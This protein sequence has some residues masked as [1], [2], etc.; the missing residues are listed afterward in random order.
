MQQNSSEYIVPGFI[1]REALNLNTA[2]VEASSL[3]DEL[4]A[5]AEEIEKCR[6]ANS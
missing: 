1:K 6:L 2:E 4:N 5:I 3:Y